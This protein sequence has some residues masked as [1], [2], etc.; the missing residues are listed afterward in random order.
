MNILIATDA[1]HPQINGV[2]RSLDT[3]VKKLEAR[4][5]N[6]SIMHAGCFNNYNCP[7]YNGYRFAFPT[8]QQVR[9]WMKN[10]KIDAVHIPTEG[11]IGLAARR[12]CINL[13]YAF[14]TSY[15][16]NFPEYAQRHFCI[17]PWIG[18]KYMKWFHSP[19]AR[20]MTVTPS[21]SEKLVEKGFDPNKL[22]IWSRGVDTD[23]FRPRERQSDYEYLDR[24]ALF[25]GRASYE[26]NIDHFLRLDTPYEKWVVGDGPDLPRL[27]REYP[28]VRFFGFVVGEELA[29]IYNHADVFVFPS[30]TDTYGL[31]M[32]EALA[33]GTPVAAYPV[34][35]PRDIV[36]DE[37]GHLSFDLEAAMHYASQ[38][39]RKACR[40]YA[41]TKSWDASAQQFL[42]NL[43]NLRGRPV[44]Y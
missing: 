13:G 7:F 5:Y 27:K 29:W 17:P 28:N 37:V 31:V 9:Q 16:T 41:L 19:A 39:S 36:T 22:V 24:I 42:E 10:H 11:P 15:H 18:Y 12:F 8:Q 4:G 3:V 38:K 14:T 35:G 1:W 2:V 20:I 25:V 43:V 21:L 6:F 34:E 30:D 26:K 32:L 44:V 40:D 33:C 23:L